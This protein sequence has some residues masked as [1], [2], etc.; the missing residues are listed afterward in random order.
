MRTSEFEMDWVEGPALPEGSL[1]IGAATEMNL[2]QSG[3]LLYH[4]FH[5]KPTEDTVR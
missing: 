4:A 5:R 1:F 3:L 2:D